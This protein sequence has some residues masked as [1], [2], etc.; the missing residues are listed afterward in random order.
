[1]FVEAKVNGRNIKALVDHGATY[2]FVVEEEAKKLGIHYTKE[3]KWLKIVE[4][5]I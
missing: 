3:L 2:S 4:L 5:S 1:M